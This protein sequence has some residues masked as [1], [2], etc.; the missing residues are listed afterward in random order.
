MMVLTQEE[1]SKPATLLNTFCR[2]FF[3]RK[4]WHSGVIAGREQ[5]KNY[6][7]G[8]GGKRPPAQ[9]VSGQEQGLGVAYDG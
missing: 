7:S 5:V 3:E 8:A 1:S 2:A 9:P 4:A 6:M